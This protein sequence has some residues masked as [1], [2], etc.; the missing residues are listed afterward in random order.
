MLHAVERRGEGDAARLADRRGNVESL[1][2]LDEP[3][4]RLA[5]GDEIGDR[6]DLEAMAACERR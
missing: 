6:N 3:L 2:L 5:V 4:A 1:D